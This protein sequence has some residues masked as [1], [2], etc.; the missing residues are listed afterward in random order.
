MAPSGI[1]I[2]AKNKNIW[3]SDFI[4]EALCGKWDISRRI[5]PLAHFDGHAV[6]SQTQSHSFNYHETGILTLDQGAQFHA[7]QNYIFEQEKA[8]FSIYFSEDPKRLFQKVSLNAT[9]NNSLTGTAEHSCPPDTYLSTY[10]FFADGT[11]SIQ[12]H[13]N[14]PRKKYSL[15]STYKK[16]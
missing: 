7:S 14:G 5:S 11:F 6:F 15:I 2:S 10:S 9:Q 16:T 1:K 3:V 13:V 4:C 12:H 8:G